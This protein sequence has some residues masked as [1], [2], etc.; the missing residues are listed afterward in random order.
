MVRTRR[1]FFLSETEINS[2]QFLGVDKCQTW[3]AEG[4]IIRP[5]SERRSQF[6][7]AREPVSHSSAS[8]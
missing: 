6:L 8:L 4:S 5:E 2:F 3:I 7:A 1:V